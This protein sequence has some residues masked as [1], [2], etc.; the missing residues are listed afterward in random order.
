[1]LWTFLC[2]YYC[3]IKA[4]IIKALLLNYLVNGIHFFIC[5]F[6]LILITTLK[7]R[8]CPPPFYW[9]G[10]WDSQ[11]SSI[12]LKITKEFKPRA[13]YGHVLGSLCS[14]ALQPFSVNWQEKL[15]KTWKELKKR[16]RLLN[17]LSS[18][19]F[20]SYLPFFSA[21]E[22][23]YNSVNCRKPVI[24]KMILVHRIANQLYLVEGNWQVPRG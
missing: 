3:Q 15:W 2:N 11:E 21:S 5:L 24:M 1:M 23:F 16:K 8:D 19:F 9:K 13:A 18:A 12:L 7:G 10:N 20:L 4:V 22:L 17:V 6:Y 14:T